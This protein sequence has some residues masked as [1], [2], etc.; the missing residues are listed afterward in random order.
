MAFY[1]VPYMMGGGLKTAYIR[2][3]NLKEARKVYNRF[4]KGGDTGKRKTKKGFHINITPAPEKDIE[5]FN[6]E[7]M[8]GPENIWVIEEDPEGFSNNK[9]F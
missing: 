4:T 9:I 1:S 6:L 5:K 7:K 2:A 8:V 3:D